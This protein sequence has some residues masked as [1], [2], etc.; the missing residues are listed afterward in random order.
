MYYLEYDLLQARLYDIITGED[1][2]APTSTSEFPWMV[3]GGGLP[4][5]S[6]KL[7]ERLVRTHRDWGNR[8]GL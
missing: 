8:L 1:Q 2:A 5:D 4:A 3:D 6:M 7:L